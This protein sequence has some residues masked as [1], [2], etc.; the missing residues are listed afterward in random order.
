MGRAAAEI[1]PKI[2]IG[3]RTSA[4]QD[5]IA[6]K[7]YFFA[8]N[9]FLTCMSLR[10]TSDQIPIGNPI[11]QHD[12]HGIIETIDA[13]IAIPYDVRFFIFIAPTKIMIP[14]ISVRALVT[15]PIGP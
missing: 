4:H 7:T 14:Q 3:Q 5:T 15:I 6:S 2:T 9:A 11:Q 1:A 12:T 13:V 10:I 8:R